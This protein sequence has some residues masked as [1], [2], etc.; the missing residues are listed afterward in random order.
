[1]ETET[2][3]A[4]APKPVHTDT[5]SA[6]AHNAELRIDVY[7]NSYDKPLLTPPA[8]HPTEE[9]EPRPPPLPPNSQQDYV[10]RRIELFDHTDTSA[11]VEM[12]AVA[13]LLLPLQV[14]FRVKMLAIFALQLLLVGVLTGLCAFYPPVNDVVQSAF[15]VQV[16]YL[17]AA[18]GALVLL[19]GALYLI[20]VHFPLN[21]LVLLFFS[22]AQAALFAALGVKFD[23]YLGVFNCSATFACVV[24]MLLLSGVRKKR[25]KTG[26]SP[27]LL[28][29]VLA[30]L[31]AYVFVAVVASG[32]Y[33]GLG[34]DFVTPEGF[35]GSLA[36]QFVLILWFALDASFMY[37]V[38]SPD[39]YMHGVIYFYTDMVL[40][41]ALAAAAAAVAAVCAACSESANDLGSCDCGCSG[42]CDWGDCFGCCVCCD[43]DAGAAAAATSN[44]SSGCLSWTWCDYCSYCWLR[45][46]CDSCGNC[47]STLSSSGAANSTPTKRDRPRAPRETEPEPGWDDAATSTTPYEPGWVE[48]HK[49]AVREQEMQRV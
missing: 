37:R 28:S 32:L 21:W 22:V 14:A 43:G 15:A 16:A 6:E 48:P 31:Y 39:E 11:N 33:I 7:L 2:P 36:F 25:S 46:T 3:A 41:V 20:R 29:P 24:I 30:G 9:P 44:T 19:L 18:A 45:M 1:M 13:Q 38:M 49:D 26:G 5:S 10:S 27:K 40:L 23:T 8:T 35:A 47:C 17:I 42:D 12:G 4:P 34:R